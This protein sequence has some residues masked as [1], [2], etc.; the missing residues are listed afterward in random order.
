MGGWVGV[1]ER[2]RDRDSDPD[3]DTDTYTD[4]DEGGREET[5]K[6][7]GVGTNLIKGGKN[8]KRKPK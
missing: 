6:R 4:T 3:T 2:E 8:Q 1:R 5:A 7:G